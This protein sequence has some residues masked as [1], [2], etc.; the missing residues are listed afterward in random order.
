MDQSI[1]LISYYS[2]A[3]LYFAL[4]I[5][6]LPNITTGISNK[7]IALAAFSTSFWFLVLA[8]Q[9]QYDVLDVVVYQSLEIIKYATWIA[10]LLSVL[11]TASHQNLTR[12]KI[13]LS[14]TIAAFSIN[15]VLLSVTITRPFFSVESL[16]FIYGTKFYLLCLT[17]VSILGLALVE[18]VMRNTHRDRLWNIKFLCL[19]TGSMFAYDFFMFSDAL[20]F[21]KIEESLL[22]SRGFI[23]IFIVPLLFI[24]ISRNPVW[25][26]ELN[27]SRRVVFHTGALAISGIYLVLMATA[28][29]YIKATGGEWGSLLQ[30][31]FFI[32]SILAFF[33]LIMSRQ[34]RARLIVYISRHFFRYHYDYRHEWVSMTKA[35]FIQNQDD[36]LA[37]RA[38][39]QISSMVNSTGGGIWLKN[40]GGIYIYTE[41]YHA[42]W[43]HLQP[44]I[45]EQ[46]FLLYLR[47]KNWIINIDEYKEDNK[48]YPGLVLPNTILSLSNAWLILPLN[49]Q[50]SLVGFITL[51]HSHANIEFNWEDYDILKISGHQAASALAQMLDSEALAN[52]RQFEAYN[53]MSAFVIHDIKTVVSQL[54]L[55]GKNAKQHKNNPAF[56]D[57]MISTTEHSVSKMQSLLKQLKRETAKNETHELDLEKLLL[58]LIQEHNNNKPVPKITQFPS[59][60]LIINVS[61]EQILSAITHIIKNA[62]E[63]T[64]DDGYINIAVEKKNHTVLINIIDNGCGMDQSFI[65]NSLFKPFSSTKGLSGMG[66]GVYQCRQYIRAAEGDISVESHLGQGTTFTITLPIYKQE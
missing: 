25:R 30:T 7:L 35:L 20:L 26:L 41:D 28:G 55:L 46:D 39:R 33:I 13:L 37:Y 11:Y 1:S 61:Q 3:I 42:N 50:T 9:L 24:T 5:R 64:S 59:N 63:A 22:V 53:Q 52:S 27:V 23:Q 51:S 48:H 2:A 66:I 45:D 29:Y 43:A 16:S 49:I 6:S 54:S 56:I 60:R 58:S 17:A 15:V 34:M 19:A 65:K 44:N 32:G 10:L 18:Q 31:I 40:E 62:Q 21:N 57:D 38:L 8:T 14:L 36:K 47:E 12:N 4:F